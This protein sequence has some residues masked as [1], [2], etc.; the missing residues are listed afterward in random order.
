M[1]SLLEAVRLVRTVPGSAPVEDIDVEHVPIKTSEGEILIE[2]FS[3]AAPKSAVNFLRY[4]DDG[5]Y[6][7]TIYHRVVRGFSIQR[8]D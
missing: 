3:G 7:Q 2:L 5:H 1:H 8:F 6:E 4:V